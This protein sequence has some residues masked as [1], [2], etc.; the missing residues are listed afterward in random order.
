MIVA[1]V[2]GKTEREVPLPVDSIHRLSFARKDDE[3]RLAR[4]LA[5]M[6]SLFCLKDFD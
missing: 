6:A 5:E 3:E 2:Q 4:Y 1:A